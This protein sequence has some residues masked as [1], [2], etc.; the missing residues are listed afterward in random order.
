MNEKKIF[1]KNLLIYKIIL[2][3]IVVVTFILLFFLCGGYDVLLNHIGVNKNFKDDEFEVHF[4][5][6]GQG[7]SAFIRFPDNTT[8]LIDAG[9]RGSANKVC[10]YI[11]DIF[12]QENLERID[13][14]VITHSD[15]DHVGG[16]KE[17]FAQF[18]VSVCYRPQM[19][20]NYENGYDSTSS[21]WTYFDD[22]IQSAY[23]EDCEI[24][25]SQ[26]GVEWSGEN[27]QV[28]FLSPIS[29]PNY[30]DTNAYSPIIRIDC[31]SASFLFTGDAE[32]NVENDVIDYSPELLDV[33]VLKVAHHGSID[34][35]SSK[36][37]SY[38]TPSVAV[39]SVGNNNGY[40]HPNQ[41]VLDRL[42]EIGVKNIYQTNLLGSIVLGVDKEGNVYYGGYIVSPLID[43]AILLTATII[44]LII[45][46]SLEPKKFKKKQ[47]KKKE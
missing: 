29:Q 23:Q 20:S 2:T 21:R 9:P 12:V 15:S 31:L 3:I 32:T 35:T 4:I 46:W 40:N 45:I 38:V 16:A 28:R 17:V 39:I 19:L 1:G 47:K 44:V 43:P 6:V 7:D 8:M 14:F 26:R 27:Y 41:E 22:A 42:A 25:Y 36:F 13:Y 11:N 37:L 33:D 18:D 34:S 5:D 30:G 24:F 10:Q